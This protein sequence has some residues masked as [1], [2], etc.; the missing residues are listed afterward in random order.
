MELIAASKFIARTIVAGPCKGTL[1]LVDLTGKKLS[2]SPFD[3]ETP[4]TVFIDGPVALLDRTAIT[5]IYGSDIISEDITIKNLHEDLIAST[6]SLTS[7]VL[8]LRL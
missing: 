5:R 7:E 6:A 8:P 2:V 1:R 4:A 3:R